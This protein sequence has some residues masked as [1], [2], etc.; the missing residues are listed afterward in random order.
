MY[1]D[2]VVVVVSGS[3]DAMDAHGIVAMVSASAHV[4]THGVNARR[5][6]CSSASIIVESA[7]FDTIRA[8][9]RC[10]CVF[11][12]DDDDEDD[13]DEGSPVTRPRRAP[14]PIVDSVV[15]VVDSIM[16]SIAM[17]VAA[18]QRVTTQPAADTHSTDAL[19][20]APSTR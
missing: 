13:D 4:V 12:D 1:G 5:R 16:N 14:Y 19:S 3:G 11:I 2:V 20:D 9:V 18:R 17:R 7:L 8:T 10:E 6:R 15:V